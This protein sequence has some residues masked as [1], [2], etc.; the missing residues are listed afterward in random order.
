MSSS[1]SGGGVGAQ[2]GFL[3]KERIIAKPGFNRWLV[4]PAAL[5]IHLCIGMAYGFSVFWLPLSKA[6]GITAPVACAPD[7]SFF[8]QVF[9][10]SCDWSVSMLSWIYTLFFIFLGCSAAIWGGWLEHAGPR[11]AGVVSALCWCGGLVI[12]ALG[13]YTHQIWLMWLGS[14]VIGGIGLGLGYISPVSTL[15]KWFPDKRGMATGM[16][17]MG[18][19]GGAMV[20][21][22][23][24][25]ALMGHFASPTSVGVWQSFLVMAAIYFVFM[26]GGALSYR[27]P[28]TGWKPEGYVPSAKKAKGMITNRHV[29]VN[30][31][32]KTPQFAL[33]W[34]VLCLNVS[35]GIGI[36]GMASPLLQEVFGGKLLGVDLAFNQLDSAQLAQ[37]AAIA[38]GFTGLLS[39]FNIGGRF[40]W[41]SFSDYI[42]RKVTYFV[43]FAL[44][45]ALY[46]SVPTLGHSG[47]IALFVAAFCIVLSMYGGG[48]ATVPAYLAD[49][50]GTQMVGAI[51][52]RLLTAWAVAGVLGPVLVTNLRDY[53]LAHGVARA[54]V[55]DTTLYILSG[56]LVLG[57]ICNAL[58]RPVADKYFMTDAELKAEQALG[59]DKGTDGT[60]VLE[61]KANPASKPLAVAAWLAVG[62][63]LA[64]GVWVTL[65]KTAVLFH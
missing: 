54:A 60:T 55:Y 13:I 4:P 56:L 61:W 49:L 27:V 5:A 32:W 21:A 58:V 34:L 48:F 14:G 52:G 57:F 41:A 8:S 47:N 15:I 17:I 1:L 10:S 40:F 22:P 39:L 25:A 64:W 26:I 45:V 59:H 42:G 51:H 62:I 20:G 31:A 6:I 16:A 65:Q 50:F 37:I 12:S 46:A 23:L 53:Q 35:A 63:P 38:A 18:F 44:G 3:S 9:S 30:V 11:K 2:P 28:P 29:H 7:L 33:V 24:A 43:F 36:L 19:G